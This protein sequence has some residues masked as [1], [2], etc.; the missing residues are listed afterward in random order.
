MERKWN[1][2][3]NTNF[4]TPAEIEMEN[5]LQKGMRTETWLDDVQVDMKSFGLMQLDV[6]TGYE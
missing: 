6:H 4:V 3:K 2:V 1:W 5:F